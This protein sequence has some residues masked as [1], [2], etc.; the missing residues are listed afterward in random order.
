MLL[1][2]DG[3]GGGVVV[4]HVCELDSVSPR[5]CSS[6]WSRIEASERMQEVV[7]SKSWRRFIFCWHHTC[8]YVARVRKRRVAWICSSG[9]RKGRVD[10]VRVVSRALQPNGAVVKVEKQ[11]RTMDQRTCTSE[12]T[13]MFTCGPLPL[14]QKDQFYL[15]LMNH[16]SLYNNSSSTRCV[17]E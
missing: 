6:S 11:H 12:G 5:I 15:F 10:W 4:S 14:F 2:G 16:I 13:C 9:S 17:P 3:G 7:G 1:G 8:V